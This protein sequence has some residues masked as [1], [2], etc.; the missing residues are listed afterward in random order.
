[1]TTQGY[2]FEHEG[3]TFTP[4][5][6]ASIAD[7]E[8]HNKEVEQQEL[9]YWATAPEHWQVYIVKHEH[10][11]MRAMG[12]GNGPETWYMAETWLGTRLSEGRVSISRFSTNLS[13]NIV[14]IRFKATNGATYYGRYGADWSQLC[15]VR[16]AKGKA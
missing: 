1:M 13:R 2:A 6:S 7:V 9:A 11:T 5:G 15:R 12:C 8:G 16:K 10:P 14:A 4:N 3:R